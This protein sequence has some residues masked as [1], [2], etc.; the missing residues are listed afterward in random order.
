[1]QNK[2]VI[3]VLP[4]SVVEK[5]AAG[6]VVERPAS[7]LKE[8]V[9]NSI[10]AGATRVDVAV[11]DA[12]FSLMRVSDNGCGMSR[13]D[14]R[15]SVLPHATSKI[16]TAD[17]LYSIATMGFRGEA[18]ASISAVSRMTVNSSDGETEGLGY[19]II[20]E[21]GVRGEAAPA[22]R[23]RG[24]TITVRD[25]FYNVPARKKFMKTPRGEQIAIVKI[26][27]QIAVP[28]PGIHFTVSVDGR[29]TL[30]LPAAATLRD[31]ICS[32]AGND[33]AAGLIECGGD[34]DGMSV[35]AYVS[36]PE[37]LQS[38]PRFQSLYV[39]LRRIDNDSVTFAVREAFAQYLGHGNR[40]SF[41]CFLD[42]DPNRTDVNVHPTKQQMKF[43]D[44]R[45]VFGFIY[46]TVKEGLRSSEIARGD[47]TGGGGGYLGGG[48]IIADLYGNGNNIPNGYDNG[49]NIPTKYNISDN[50]S[51]GYD[52]NNINN[53]SNNILNIYNDDNNIPTT[54]QQPTLY[55]PSLFG[56]ASSPPQSTP[57]SLAAISDISE[58]G[59]QM[60]QDL[61]QCYQIHRM[62]ILLHI[63]NGILFIDQ[64]AAHER[65]LYEQALADMEAGRPVSQQLLFPIVFEM[66]GTEKAVLVSNRESF[67]NLGF[68]ISDFGGNA[69]SVSALPAFLK[70][71]QAEEAIR[72]MV[73]YLLDGRDPEKLKEPQKRF[74]AAF[75]CGAAIKS[76]QKLS[77]E[78]MNALIN[79]LFSTNNPYTCPHGRPTRVRISLDELV[80]RFLRTGV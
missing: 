57:E 80:R 40:P 38:K 77:Q 42:V 79:A 4:Q 21:G 43:D 60:P 50:I 11:E 45:A 22:S 73:R 25:I 26:L 44:E 32:V 15:R 67:N 59:G 78:E 5:I 55:Q 13:E 52:N 14:I 16:R 36:S 53:N 20:V 39:N 24:T 61:I 33:F 51:G 8:L 65:V 27:E 54:P 70:D 12:G 47:L 64:H 69:V 48:G 3:E 62:F 41:F 28:F 75:A 9:E 46:H 23:S 2:N 74:A 31:R 6:E 63:K 66:S 58:A 68:E 17:D 34:G 37:K 56:Q 18:L 10:D 7:V 76:G 30:N 19:E 1:M 35:L 72:E 49:N 71:G 29:Q